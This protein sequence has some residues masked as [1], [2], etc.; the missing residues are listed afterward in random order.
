MSTSSVLC[1]AVLFLRG[2]MTLERGPTAAS[3]AYCDT[4]R[5]TSRTIL[6]SEELVVQRF[7]WVAGEASFTRAGLPP[8]GTED[9]RNQAAKQVPL[10]RDENGKASQEVLLSRGQ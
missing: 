6:P 2:A 10:S 1:F 7:Q 8:G 5:K 9:D 4:A 3:L